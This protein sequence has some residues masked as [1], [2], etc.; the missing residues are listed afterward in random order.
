MDV[1]ID[2][3][4]EFEFILEDASNI[5][6]MTLEKLKYNTDMMIQSVVDSGSFI[7]DVTK[8]AL[9][10]SISVPGKSKVKL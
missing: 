2:I 8:D 1:D 6:S 7:N 10:D 9:I 4:A 5:C 3:P